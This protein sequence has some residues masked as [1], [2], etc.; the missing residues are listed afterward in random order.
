VLVNLVENAFDAITGEEGPPPTNGKPEPPRPREG[1]VTLI[2]RP[3]SRTVKLVVQDDGPGIPEEGRDKVFEPFF[4]SKTRGSG[5][6][7]YLVK[8]TVLAH[9]GSIAL[10]S[11]GG[12]GTS[13]A[14]HWPRPAEDAS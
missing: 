11:R 12:R 3:L 6:G 5:L 13:V 1:V 10:A 8:E 2:V 7:L 9:G 14:M 4:T